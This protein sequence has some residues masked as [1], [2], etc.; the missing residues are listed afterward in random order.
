MEEEQK[1]YD[2]LAYFLARTPLQ[3][4]VWQRLQKEQ[5]GS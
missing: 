2:S 5:I 4:V 3:V 1:V